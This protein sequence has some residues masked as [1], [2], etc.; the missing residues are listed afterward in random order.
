M[1]DRLFKEDI[2]SSGVLLMTP[3]CVLV[4]CRFVTLILLL[5]LNTVSCSDAQ[6]DL[7]YFVVVEFVTFC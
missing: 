7:V 4:N 6:F 1:E 2:D 5:S 3:S